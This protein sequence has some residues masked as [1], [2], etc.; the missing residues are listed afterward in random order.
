LLRESQKRQN[1][2]ESAEKNSRRTGLKKLGLVVRTAGLIASNCTQEKYM[3]NDFA[4]FALLVRGSVWF[5]C[6]YTFVTFV[7]TREAEGASNLAYDD[8]QRC[9]RSFLRRG[10]VSGNMGTEAKISNS[11]QICTEYCGA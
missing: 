8:F 2:F 4:E 7:R 9:W 10:C 1:C 3:G 6:V 11:N 5:V